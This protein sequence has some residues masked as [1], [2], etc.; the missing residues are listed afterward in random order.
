[1]E[2]SNQIFMH[3]QTA[4]CAVKW[5]AKVAIYLQC[6]N[7]HPEAIATWNPEAMNEEMSFMKNNSTRAREPPIWLPAS[8]DVRNLPWL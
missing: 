8:Y 6:P 1:M 2:Y 3:K 7:S 5:V 4:A